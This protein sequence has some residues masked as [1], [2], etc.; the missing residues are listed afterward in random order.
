MQK[1]FVTAGKAVSDQLGKDILKQLRNGLADKAL[2]IQRACANTLQALARRTSFLGTLSEIDSV[3]AP[4]FKAFEG[5]D[6]QTRRSLSHLIAS[7]LAST[8]VEGSA[9]VIEPPKKKK[10][11]GVD[12]DDEQGNP[13]SA[14]GQD[15]AR[16]LLTTQEML[17]QL[18]GPFN[19]QGTSR[20]TRNAIIDV[21]ATLFAALGATYVEAHYG[22][23]VTHLVTDIVSF[24][25]NTQSKHEILIVRKSVGI[26][27]RDLIGVRLLSE[28]G[29]IG[30]IR[31]LVSAYLKRWSATPMPGVVAPTHLVLVPVLYEVAGLLE[32]LGNAPPPV[33]EVLQEPLLRL[34][35]H[36][37]QTVRVAA[38]WC[39]RCFCH[40]TPLRL[41]RTITTI[42]SDLTKDV[43][44]LGTPVA[45]QDIAS[46]MMGRAYA[47]SSLIAV[48]PERP[49][50]VSYDLSAN[51]L[52]LAIS[53]L[54]R[55]GEH[56][57]KIATV[58]VQV[59]WTLIGALMTL[60]PSFVK[61]HLPQLLVL[62]RNALPKPTSKDS[63][64]GARGEAEWKFLLDVREA[65]LTSILSFL[66]H[67][68]AQLV[69]LDVARRLVALLGNTLTFIN[70]FTSLH[71]DALREQQLSASSTSL[72]TG[73][74]PPALTLSERETMLRRRIFQ[75][76]TV[77][78]P[79]SATE[80]LHPSLLAASVAVFAEP[81]QYGGGS[82]TQ[83]AI[84]ASA[85]NFTS[86]WT[87]VD[88]YASGVTS[89]VAGDEYPEELEDRSGSGTGSNA[90]N[91][92]GVEVEIQSL[93][94]L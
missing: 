7:L 55:A 54:K 28:Q 72:H 80:S 4:A 18:S 16:T 93:V 6:H 58:E 39:L 9:P 82:A 35:T 78:G 56:E 23:I 85:G 46:R 73:A 62:W 68:L 24:I 53:L 60:G 29:Q 19:R 84:A 32:Q 12:D 34:V 43:A 63:S 83:A 45:P 30:A 70:T 65:T 25:R 10:S 67:N 71:A 94:S 3:L 41:S 74:V 11:T 90:L 27:L 76:F 37:S 5:A 26:L 21:Y 50:Y 75:C 52:D 44:M 51:V 87:S 86:I 38:A 92:D 66:R 36:P 14:A 8:Q 81:D 42:L 13:P 61:L 77:L 20:K 57:V 69:N 89:L 64:A 59:A 47:L 33:Q 88:G 91:R 22:E 48:I 17:K 1:A 31:E 2:S 15:T 79:S 40:T 49:L